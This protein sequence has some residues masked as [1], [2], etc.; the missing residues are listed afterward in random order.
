MTA[1]ISE[2]DKSHNAELN[3]VSDHISHTKIAD[4][5]KESSGKP[6]HFRHYDDETMHHIIQ[7]PESAPKDLADNSMFPVVSL[8]LSTLVFD[9]F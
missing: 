2:P 1:A 9:L 5:L 3:F 4:L 8:V 7:H 6:V